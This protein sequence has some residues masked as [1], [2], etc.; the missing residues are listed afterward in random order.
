MGV[1]YIKITAFPL[2][3]SYAMTPDKAQGLSLESLWVD[4]SRR[5]RKHMAY[6]ALSRCKSL[7]LVYLGGFHPQCIDIHPKVRAF[8]DK[9]FND[10]AKEKITAF[11]TALEKYVPPE[12]K[13]AIKRKATVPIPGTSQQRPKQLKATVAIA[14]RPQQKKKE[15]SYDDIIMPPRSAAIV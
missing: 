13:A 2:T 9:E 15:T 1:G 6:V 4:L 7:D 8:Y 12:A 3:L 10:E 5:T 11:A 14:A